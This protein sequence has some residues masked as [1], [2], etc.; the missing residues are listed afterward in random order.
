[1]TFD[2][3]LPDLKQAVLRIPS[4]DTNTPTLDVPLDGVGIDP[5]APQISV[6][7]ALVHFGNQHISRIPTFSRSV[8]ISNAASIGTLD[9]GDVFVT[10]VDEADFRIVSDSA[11][12][13][14]Q[15]GES[16]ILTM[17]FDPS[18]PGIKTA[19]LQIIS[20]DTDQG[21]FDVALDGNGFDLNPCVAPNPTNSFAQ[22]LCA[23]AL[24][25]CP[26]IPFPGTLTGAT[27]DG[28][29]SCGSL[30]PDVWYR[31][32]AASNGV[33]TV[34]VSNAPGLLVLSAHSGCPGNANNQLA[35]V[36]RA[37]GVLSNQLQLT[38]NVTNHAE[39]L[40]RIAGNN[41]AG[42]DFLMS[43][44][45]PPCFNFDLNQNGIADS[46]EFDFGDAPAPYP[47]LLSSNGARHAAFS[48]LFLGS[49]ID[50]E[51]EGQPDANGAGDNLDGGL[52][53]EDGVLF[54]SPL[55][56]GQPATVEVTSSG[57]GFLNAWVD[58][59]GDGDWGD[60][61]EAIFVNQAV[62]RGLNRL[63]FQ[64]P[65]AATPTAATFARFRLNSAGNLA[66]TGAATDGEVED[67]LVSIDPAQEVPG[68]MEV[69]ILQVAA[70]INGDS[71]AQFVLLDARSEERRVGKECR[72][73][74]SPYH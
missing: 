1:M 51:A 72:S 52:N 61:G 40:I 67:Y 60:S 68:Q 11:Q 13:S 47:T 56:P 39:V 64:V 73:R 35:C 19:A 54:T 5:N 36:T 62:E 21:E 20:N 41:P 44:A 74:W 15:P 46:C 31:Y 17:V 32:V 45:G 16:R 57:H 49:L 38:L 59:N 2:P 14:L 48:G 7:P 23:D 63:T 28:A 70:G 33:L 22:N 27:S 18:T 43:L 10:G 12:S 8:T 65:A 42:R 26:G 9:L 50:P 58:F 66:P 55:I 29:S 69:R 25:V 3:S 4:N 37:A 30:L 53:D 6:T 71:E 24:L 34:T